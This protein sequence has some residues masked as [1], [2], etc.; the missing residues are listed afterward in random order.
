MV[1]RPLFPRRKSNPQHGSRNPISCPLEDGEAFQ[2]GRMMSSGHQL[3]ATEAERRPNLL[4][5]L[6]ERDILPTEPLE[7][8]SPRGLEPPQDSLEGCC[9][10]PLCYED[11]IL[12]TGFEPVCSWHRILSATCLPVPPQE[13]TRTGARTRTGFP[14]GA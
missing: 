7:H 1:F 6:E 13:R 10:N 9:T 4:P 3:Y 11:L 8:M 12:L 5:S 14:M 2:T